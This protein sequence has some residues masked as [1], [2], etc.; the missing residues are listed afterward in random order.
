MNIFYLHRK[1]RRCA[2]YHCDKHIVK[3]P[4]EAAQLL[5]TAIWLC[6]PDLV[7]WDSEQLEWTY[8]G[9]RVY[10]KTHTNHPC[11]VWARANKKNWKWLRKFGIRLCEEYTHRYGK[12]HKT[13]GVLE[14][15]KCPPLPDGEFTPPPQCMPDE[16][17]VED[18]CVTAY[19]RY[20]NG[21]KKDILTWKNREVPAWVTN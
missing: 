16:Y 4:I 7:V 8:K 11:A 9:A 20:Y 21:A 15:L 14:A 2:K 19:R 1:R 13:Q 5:C 18:D 10:R 6:C 3:M 12:V 17:K